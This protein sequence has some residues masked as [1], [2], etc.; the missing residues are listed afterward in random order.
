MGNSGA[1]LVKTSFTSSIKYKFHVSGFRMISNYW[2]LGRNFLGCRLSHVYLL[3]DSSVPSSEVSDGGH[4]RRQETGLD[5]WIHLL[6]ELHNGV[7]YESRGLCSM[8][9]LPGSPFQSYVSMGFDLNCNSYIFHLVL[10]F[11]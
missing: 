4:C 9:S 6:T 10:E 2:T 5:G 1:A 11:S 3:Q 8:K 7:A